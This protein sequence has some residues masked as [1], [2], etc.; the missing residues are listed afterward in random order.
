MLGVTQGKDVAV[1][2]LDRKVFFVYV[3]VRCDGPSTAGGVEL[4]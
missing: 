4:L 1:E 2:Q 3:L